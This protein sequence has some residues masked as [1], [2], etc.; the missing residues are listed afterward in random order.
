MLKQLKTLFNDTQ[1]RQQLKAV[2]SLADAISLIKT[3]SIKKG[4]RFSSDS[5]SLLMENNFEPLNERELIVV[6]GGKVPQ[7][8]APTGPDCM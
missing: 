8:P 2:N 3:A 5:L 1:L 7:P 4:Y 6:A